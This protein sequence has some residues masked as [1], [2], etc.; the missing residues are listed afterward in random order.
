VVKQ[1]PLDRLLVETDS[2]FL[3]PQDRRGQRNEPAFVVEAARA[4]AEVKG[5]G[6]EHVAAA[7]AANAALLFGLEL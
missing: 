7:T 4:V 5:I 2:P 1:L 6:L 3:P